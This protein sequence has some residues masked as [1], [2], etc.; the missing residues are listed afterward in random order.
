MLRNW[1]FPCSFHFHLTSRESVS[2][3]QDIASTDAP[4][5]HQ[6]RNE[7]SANKKWGQIKVCYQM[8]KVQLSNKSLEWEQLLTSFFIWILLSA[9]L[10]FSYYPISS[11]IISLRRYSYERCK[12]MQRIKTVWNC[13]EKFD[14]IVSMWLCVK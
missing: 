8:W 2:T 5:S 14:W 1:F 13:V 12:E 11:G 6:D 3:A 9:P 7:N 4:F 10:G